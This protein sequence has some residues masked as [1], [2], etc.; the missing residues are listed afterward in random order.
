MHRFRPLAVARFR[1][2]SLLVTLLLAT[3]CSAYKAPKVRVGD[4]TVVE[5][6]EEAL[7]LDILLELENPNIEPLD[8]R[9]V[10]YTLVV[11]GRAVYQ[12]KRA[13]QA[14]LS[15]AGKRTLTVPG[16][17]RYDRV[18]WTP[19]TRPAE[20]DWSIRGELVY[21]TPGELAEILLDTKLREPTASF[22]GKGRVALV[23]IEVIEVVEPVE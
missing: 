1:T 4:A 11:D 5:I 19:G 13:A 12:G 7:R 22:S 20:V 8:L 2:S 9:R 3:G 23:E 21:I 14:T 17:V 16:V 6:A 10:N 15:R 18:D